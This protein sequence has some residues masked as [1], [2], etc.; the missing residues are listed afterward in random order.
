MRRLF[1][2]IV[3]FA[4]MLFYAKGQGIA[5]AL[6]SFNDGSRDTVRTLQYYPQGN[7]FVSVNQL[8]QFSLSYF[9]LYHR[10]KKKNL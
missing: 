7:A 2:M 8:S 5:G 4:F 10:R 6:Q 1:L 9:R 3:L